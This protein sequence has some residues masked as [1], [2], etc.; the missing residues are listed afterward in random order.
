LFSELPEGVAR[1]KVIVLRV[2]R[3]SIARAKVIVLSVAR[4]R[5]RE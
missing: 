1:V 5:E 4:E 3:G 2:A